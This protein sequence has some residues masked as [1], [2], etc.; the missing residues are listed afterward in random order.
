M[1]VDGELYQSCVEPEFAHTAAVTS[2]YFPPLISLVHVNRGG[3]D[4]LELRLRRNWPTYPAN[5][6]ESIVLEDVINVLC[7]SEGTLYHVEHASYAVHRSPILDRS[8]S[9]RSRPNAVTENDATLCMMA[10]EILELA[11]MQRKVQ[12]FVQD[13]ER[14]FVVLSLCEV[15]NVLLQE[16]QSRIAQFDESQRN[17]GM[18]LQRF[19]LYIQPAI[20]TFEVLQGVIAKSRATGAALLNT[21]AATCQL[22][23]TGDARRGLANHLFKQAME[24]YCHLVDTWISFGELYDPCQE[25]F[26]VRKGPPTEAS[27]EEQTFGIDWSRVPNVMKDIAETILNTGMYI[28]ILARSKGKALPNYQPLQFTSVEELKAHVATLHQVASDELVKYI[29]ADCNLMEMLESVHRF[30]LLSRA[31]Y[32][33]NILADLDHNTLHESINLSF[34]EAVAQ[35]SL[36]NDAYKH[37]YALRLVDGS[38]PLGLS[39]RPDSNI[40]KRLKLCFTVE[41][42]MQI[43]FSEDVMAK[44]QTAFNFLL[45]LK[46]TEHALSRIWLTHMKWKR[47][48]LMPSA[49]LR[50]NYTFVIVERMLFL[51]R[52]I[53]YLCTVEV[54]ER[55]FNLMLQTYENH[56]KNDK[57]QQSFSFIVSRHHQFVDQVTKDCMIDDE[58]VAP[59]I[60]RALSLCNIFATQVLEFL[61][62]RETDSG[63]ARQPDRHAEL[64][65]ATKFTTDLLHNEGY[66]AMVGTASHQ[67]D[68]HMRALLALLQGTE[69]RHQSS[70]LLRLTYNGYFT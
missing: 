58:A 26:V 22:Y 65:R 38:A 53:A 21:L 46:Q 7:G 14:G 4:A 39:T 33:T 18:G 43:F 61:E 6:K 15:L 59:S 49:Q 2:A 23:G 17:V 42:P 35:S 66:I 45:Q 70:L 64:E 19:K 11:V 25:F 44:Y 34:Q 60:N 62:Q 1:K 67:F 24:A 48:P 50:L 52:N 12:D 68:R 27:E 41:W 54:T 32:V 51:C 5:V 8:W 63:A 47:L 40:S 37:L 9:T 3:S 29:V 10:E 36:R 16:L 28:R 55:N 56:L 30:L 31:D 69:E 13:N 57:A 20:H